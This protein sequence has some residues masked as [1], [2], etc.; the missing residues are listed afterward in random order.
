MIRTLTAALVLV[1][2]L[3]SATRLLADM[4]AASLYHLGDV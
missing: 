4:C 3:L 2:A 1:G